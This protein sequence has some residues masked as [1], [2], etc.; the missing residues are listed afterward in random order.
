MLA[1]Q[2]AVE[3]GTQLTAEQTRLLMGAKNQF[4]ARYMPIS[5]A[6]FPTNFSSMPSSPYR[7]SRI[8]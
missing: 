8:L 1:E 7:R 6:T 4:R 5:S 3:Y 2:M